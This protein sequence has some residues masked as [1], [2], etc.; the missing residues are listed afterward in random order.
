MKKADIG[1]IGLAVMGENLVIN[2]ESKGFTVAVYNRTVEKVDAFVE[3]RAKG[4]NIIGCH[5]MQELADITGFSEKKLDRLLNKGTV[6]SES[7]TLTAEICTVPSS[8]MSICVFVSSTIFLMILPPGPMTF[9]I[10]ST[11]MCMVVT[12][13]AYGERSSFGFGMHSSI[14]PR[15]NARPR[16]ACSSAEA[17][18]SRVM[19]AILMSI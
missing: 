14:L 5:S 7:S 1:L 4:K 3:G 10:L 9:R 11:L 18:I 16:F 6:V 19:P 13:G 12:R 15:I 2:M 17:R 8:S